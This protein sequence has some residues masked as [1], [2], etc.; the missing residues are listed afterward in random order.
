MSA[1]RAQNSSPNGTLSTVRR[2]EQHDRGDR[3]GW[4]RGCQPGS[5]RAGGPKIDPTQVRRD[6]RGCRGETAFNNRRVF[7]GIGR[8][9]GPRIRRAHRRRPRN[10]KIHPGVAGCFGNGASPVCAVCLWRRVGATDQNAGLTPATQC[11]KGCGRRERA[12]RIRSFHPGGIISG[13]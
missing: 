6:Q 13:N 8:W 5:L 11:P 7:A 12:G 1:M 4:I 10:W 3:Y 2:L 9:C